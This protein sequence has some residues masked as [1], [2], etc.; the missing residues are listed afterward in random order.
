[1]TETD[2]RI[3]F[4]SLTVPVAT[5]DPIEDGPKVAVKGDIEIARFVPGK[6]HNHRRY[7][8]VWNIGARWIVATEQGGKVLRAAIFTYDLGKDDKT[9]IFD[10]TT[11]YFSEPRA[12]GRGQTGRKAEFDRDR[13]TK[14]WHWNGSA[15]LLTPPS[16]SNC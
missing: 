10:R 14:Y 2:I 13:E 7:I 8:F 1:L 4:R 6:G 12:R 11:H 16:R 5:G 3:S 15:N 9:A